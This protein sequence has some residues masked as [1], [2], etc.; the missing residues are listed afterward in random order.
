MPTTRL[1][2]AHLKPFKAAAVL[3]SVTLVVAILSWAKVV[4]VPIALAILLTFLLSPVVTRLDTWGMPRIPAVLVVVV[5]AGLLLASLTWLVAFQVRSLANDL[6]NYREN[7][8]QKAAALSN[9]MRGGVMDNVQETLQDAT[10]NLEEEANDSTAREDPRSSLEKPILVRIEPEESA[11]KALSAAIG[12]LLALTPALAGLATG[13]LVLVLVIFMLINREDLRNRL[14]SLAASESLAT[15]TKALDD[16]GQRISRYLTMQLIIN[17]TFGLAV[18]IGLLLIGVPYALLWALCAA[19]LRYIPYVGP[20]IA[21]LMPLSV[22]LITSPGWTQVLLVLGL[23]LVLELLSNNIMEPWLYGRGVGVSVVALITSAAFWTWIWGPIGLIL[24]TPLTVCLVVTGKYVPALAFFARLLGDRPAL[25]PDAAFLQRLLAR[26][27]REASE[28]VRRYRAAY[29]PETVYDQVFVPALALTRKYRSHGTMGADDESFVLAS[30]RAIL[31]DLHAE[32][33]GRSTEPEL[34]PADT[35]TQ[36]DALEAASESDYSADSADDDS[37]VIEQTIG[38]TAPQNHASD[39]PSLRVMGC[40]AHQEAEELT[41][42]MLDH[43]VRPV[44][45]EVDV[46]STRTLPSDIIARVRREKPLAVVIAALPPGGLVQ[47]HYLC[48]LLRKRFP[49]LGIVVGCW[50]YKGSFDRVIVK[51]RSAGAHYVTTSLQG[52]REHVISLEYALAP[53]QKE[54]L[55]ADPQHL[56]HVR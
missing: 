51:F 24:T 16:V 9:S 5:T 43:L 15:P 22:S 25:P 34:K 7:I 26:D 17:G 12:S 46:L 45:L 20:W 55:R 8:R 32:A 30:T 52:A 23:F 38:T 21:A 27:D 19:V 50:G 41:L 54:R 39:A 53:S 14:V 40:A 28:I 1:S 13:G 33:S 2:A 56:S 10:Q 6:P 3:L 48:K 31:A 36:P 29:P 47:A 11:E 37:E 35:G 44:G 42:H 4:L 18:G 49:Q